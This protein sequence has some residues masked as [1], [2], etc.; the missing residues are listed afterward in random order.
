M[1][2]GL[3]ARSSLTK[4]SGNAVKYFSKRPD[5]ESKTNHLGTLRTRHRVSHLVTNV[6]TMFNLAVFHRMQII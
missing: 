3:G 1:G 4:K 6:A 2:D 5:P